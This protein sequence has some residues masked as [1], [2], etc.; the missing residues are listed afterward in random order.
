MIA[1]VVVFAIA[2]VATVL[3]YRPYGLY[4]STRWMPYCDR[5]EVF[6]LSGDTDGD[7]ATGFPVRPYEKYARILDRKTLT[8]S[9][10]VSLAGLWRAQTFGQHFQALCHDP[11]YGFRFYRG[12]VVNFETSICFHCSNFYY[13]RARQVQ[14]GGVDLSSPNSLRYLN[15]FRLCF[16]IRFRRMTRKMQI[17]RRV[18]HRSESATLDV[19]FS[20]LCAARRSTSGF[21]VKRLWRIF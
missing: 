14:L 3:V 7:E 5:V 15:G 13:S 18:T 4:V 6:H 20:M 9:E 17:L 1:T 12:P 8:G 11:A 19:A 21:D 2:I 16:P 10:A